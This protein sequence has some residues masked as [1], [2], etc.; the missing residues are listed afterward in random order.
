MGLISDALPWQQ[1]PSL[2][3]QQEQHWHTW[4][5]WLSSAGRAAGRWL[6]WLSPAARQ[7]VMEL[8]LHTITC[9]STMIRTQQRRTISRALHW[10]NEGHD[11]CT[12]LP[13][14]S[15]SFADHFISDQVNI[16]PLFFFYCTT[17]TCLDSN[18]LFW[19][20]PDILFFFCFCVCFAKL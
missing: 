9:R 16:K 19:E 10:Q 8:S 7:R 1:P 2:N 13:G 17:F 11:N 14:Q 18:F 15:R 5:G 20:V 12:G 3:P 6:V 4:A